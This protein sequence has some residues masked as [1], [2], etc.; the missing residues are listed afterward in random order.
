MQAP[1]IKKIGIMQP[2]VFPYIGYF[3]LINSVDQ[4]VVY[5]DVNHIKRGWI[6]RN[7]FLINNE[8]TL[9]SLS[10]RNASSNK[11]IKDLEFVDNFGKLE[12]TIE[13]SYSKAP[14]FDEVFSMIRGVCSFSD[15][16]LGRFIGNSLIEI[17]SYLSIDTSFVYSSDV[18]YNKTLKGQDKIISLCRELGATNYINM[19]GGAS[20][21]DKSEFKKNKIELNFLN[22]K[23]E[24]YEQFGKSFVPG[25]SIIDVLMFNSP[26]E[27]RKMLNAYELI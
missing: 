7:N 6:N 24:P 21:Y 8:K 4:F 2:Y 13:M 11:L 25:L 15:K 26:T 1:K 23:I 10:V 9:F 22:P 3:Q 18:E 12:A 5:D 17:S 27:I 20:L 19:I 14:Y 16:S